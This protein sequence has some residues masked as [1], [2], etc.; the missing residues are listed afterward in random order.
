MRL[1]VVLILGIAIGATVGLLF[2]PRTGS[3]TREALRNRHNG[4]HER[5]NGDDADDL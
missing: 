5:A 1:I 2:A 3:E 4:W